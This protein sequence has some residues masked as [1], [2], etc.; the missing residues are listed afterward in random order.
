MI[1]C[2]CVWDRLRWDSGDDLWWNFELGFG[3]LAL[4]LWLC[5]TIGRLPG[6]DHLC[7]T[8]SGS[9]LS[10]QARLL[11]HC[12]SMETVSTDMNYNFKH[13]GSSH[14]QRK[15]CRTKLDSVVKPNLKAHE[16]N[17]RHDSFYNVQW[18]P[19]LRCFLSVVVRTHWQAHQ[20]VPGPQ[21]PWPTR[22]EFS[23][24]WIET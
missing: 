20:V 14:L 7:P 23:L 5:P 16:Q 3:F 6:Q 1:D 13:L 15:E 18:S 9:S 19:I 12:P 2:A 10:Y 24:C 17:M 11:I 21:D 8:K 4:D 22:W